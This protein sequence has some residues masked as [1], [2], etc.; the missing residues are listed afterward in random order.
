MKAAGEGLM[1]PGPDGSE[2]LSIR[3]GEELLRS[4]ETR[5]WGKPLALGKVIVSEHEFLSGKK[6]SVTYWPARMRP[7]R[8]NM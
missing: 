3:M 7:Y 2:F 1:P 4:L 5:E 6:L 8:C